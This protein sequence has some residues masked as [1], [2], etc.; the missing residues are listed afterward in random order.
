D[1]VTGTLLARLPQR[2]G[3]QQAAD[4]VGAEGRLGSLHGV[5][6]DRKRVANSKWRIARIMDKRWRTGNRRRYFA[7][8]IRYAFFCSSSTRYSLFAIR[9]S[10]PTRLA[11]PHTVSATS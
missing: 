10:N 9:Y 4:V 7:S 6:P 11:Y 2:R 3:P 8:D 5:A 1:L